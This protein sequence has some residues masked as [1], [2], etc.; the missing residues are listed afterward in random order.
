MTDMIMGRPSTYRLL[1][2]EV[3]ETRDFEA[4]TTADV[5]RIARNASQTGIRHDRYF[6]CKTNKQTRITT[7]T[8][9][10]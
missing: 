10:R 9:I 5:T 4:P 1:D 6:R 3:G 2:L 7:V 8:R